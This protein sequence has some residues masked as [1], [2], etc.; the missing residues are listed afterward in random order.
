MIYGE[1]NIFTL[2]EMLLIAIQ[3]SHFCIACVYD[4]LWGLHIQSKYVAFLHADYRMTDKLTIHDVCHK[5]LL[6]LH[7]QHRS[8]D[9]TKQKTCKQHSEKPGLYVRLDTQA[10]TH[11]WNQLQ[12]IVYS[13]LELMNNITPSMHKILLLLHETTAKEDP[14]CW[15]TKIL[16]QYI[17]S[18]SKNK[19][20]PDFLTSTGEVWKHTVSNLI[21]NGFENDNT[22]GGEISLPYMCSCRKKK[23]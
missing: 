1:K 9:K 7:W 13:T 22:F 11:W 15:E 3:C 8:E 2:A 6:N 17:I 4:Y 23:N 21:L 12:R 18:K 16:K 20:L 14:K 19:T 5:F 10:H